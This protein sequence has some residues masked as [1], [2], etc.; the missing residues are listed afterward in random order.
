MATPQKTEPLMAPICLTM[1]YLQTL[2]IIGKITCQ[3][4]RGIGLQSTVSSSWYG[5]FKTQGSQI[6]FQSNS[7]SPRILVGSLLWVHETKTRPMIRR[8]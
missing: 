5:L 3:L 7:L 4:F 2:Q 8:F 1:R 6:F